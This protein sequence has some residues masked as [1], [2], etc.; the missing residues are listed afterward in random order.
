M[1]IRAVVVSWNSAAVLPRCLD[2]LRGADWP[3]QVE[4]VVVDNGSTDGTTDR[5][6]D[7]HPD[8]HLVQ[9]GGNLGFGAAVNRGLADL[10]GIDAVALVNPDAFVDPAWARPL[11]DALDADPSVGAACPKIL[12]EAPDAQGRPVI[13]NAGNELG[14][15]FEPRDRGLGEVDAGQYDQ[16]EDVWGWCGGGV[17]LR[18]EYL[19]DV[20]PFDERLFLY[21]EDVDLSW[22]GLRRGWRYRYVPS[23]VV[24]HRHRA[25]SGGART[26]LL[27]HLNRRNR[28][29]VVTR[30]AGLRGAAIAWTRAAGGI[31]VAA[32]AE[33]AAPLLHRRRPDTAPLRR[34]IRAAIDA[35]HVLRGDDPPIPGLDVKDEGE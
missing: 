19:D 25:S 16:P 9:T 15:T 26:P 35:A 18:R 29:V 14:P 28:L 8:V 2:H 5:W 32:L 6:P 27:D 4:L 10:D 22:R 21:V 34:R 24:H 20:G 7:R 11:A 30:H 31:L 13:Q 17:L 12:L 3:G 23:A 33:L 1:R